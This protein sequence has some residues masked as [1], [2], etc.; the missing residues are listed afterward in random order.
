MNNK[1]FI[2]IIASIAIGFIF[3]KVFFNQYDGTA[4]SAFNEGEKT[5]FIT[6]GVVSSLDKIKDKDSILYLE[7]EDGYHIYVG[8][9]K[10][11]KSAS[12]IKEIYSNDG[13]NTSI[14]EVYLSNDKFLSILTEYDK[15]LS[16]ATS[17]EDTKSIEKIVLSNYKEMVLENES[18]N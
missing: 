4:I 5:Y 8:I 9:T 10:D 13:N 15:I 6:I 2:P 12:K 18:I 16:I 3:G 1:F 11:S 14:E 17:S 7:K